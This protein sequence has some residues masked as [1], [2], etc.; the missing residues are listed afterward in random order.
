M[1]VFLH[2]LPA[3]ILTAFVL[4]SLFKD[5]CI[6]NTWKIEIQSSSW[7][8]NRLFNV[9]YN[10]DNVSLLGKG[11]TDLLLLIKD[12]SFLSLGFLSCNSSPFVQESPGPVHIT[13]WKMSSETST[14][15]DTLA[16]TTADE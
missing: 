10:T 4:E 2:V 8:K 6:A 9:Q 3:G 15:A 12:S 11:Q 5:I 1:V 16:S 14:N 13:L 7:A